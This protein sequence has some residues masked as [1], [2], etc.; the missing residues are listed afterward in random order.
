MLKFALYA[1]WFTLP[2]LQGAIAFRMWRQKIYRQ[3][4]LFF[5]Y[6]LEQLVRF[7]ILVYYQQ[8]D[9]RTSYAH[10]YAG[11]GAFEAILQ[12]GI[13]CELFSDVLRPYEGI[14]H[15][16]L[17]LLRRTSVLFLL[18]AILVSAYSR[19]ADS[20][21]FLGNMFAIDRSAE[22]V[23]AGL[24]LLLAVT[25]SLMALEWSPRT[26]WI[27]LG[28][29][30]FTSV[31]LVAYTIRSQTGP[32]TQPILSLISNA[33]YVFSV[34]I[35][36]RAFYAESEARPPSGKGSA[37]WDMESWNRALLQLLRR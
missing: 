9:L 22:I 28:F 14:R 18:L 30:L 34:L 20:S 10:A 36:V 21:R 37:D 33:A 26:L 31:D 4:P 29:G 5:V 7:A 35:W 16:G 19:G 3:Y 8:P 17:S 2:P 13:V 15:F 32:S 1:F 24:L 6:T 23:Q 11:L 25:S 27:A 12:I